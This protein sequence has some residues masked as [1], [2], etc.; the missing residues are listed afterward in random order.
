MTERQPTPA[1]TTESAAAAR[2]AVLGC[3]SFSGSH[4]VRH[5]LEQ[6][7]TVL[8][9]SRT[10]EPHAIFWPLAWDGGEALKPRF[11]FV[12]ADLNRELPKVSAAFEAF[13]PTHVVNFAA[14]GMVAESWKH[15]LDYFRTNLTAQ[16]AL[17]EELRRMPGLKKFVHVGT[18]EVY[19]HTSG[20]IT[21]DAP[22]RPTT[23]Y[24]AS[25][26]ACDLHLDTY[27][28]EYGF[29]VVWTRAANVFG[30]GQQLYRI[31]PRTLISLRL[32]R[33]LPL[34]GGGLST[35]SFIHIRDVCRATL[36]LALRA[37][38]GGRYHISTPRMISIR[39]LVALMCTQIGGD[40]AK[41]VD[42]TAERPG[43]DSAYWLNSDK[44]RREFG[45][46]DRISLEAGLAETLAWVDANLDAIR[47]LPAE[48]AHQS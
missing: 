47:G 24:A 30:P 46:A 48:Y 38:P 20:E 18:P 21:E 36:E 14:L 15:P 37:A 32:G 34:H 31:V 22:L 13:Q 26:A 16:V 27:V 5:A 25:R 2:I 1:Q 42:V 12:R 19:G 17:H 8:G 41:L 3:N 44:V 4:F 33:K 45:W 10:A 39:D 9:L 6:G 7:A 40:F 11:T 29:P 23:P 43:K 28:R 35:R